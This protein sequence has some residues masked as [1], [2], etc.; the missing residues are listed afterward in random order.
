M[1]NAKNMNNMNPQAVEAMLAIA[2][3]KLGVSAEELKNQLEQGK[4]DNALK[5]VPPKQAQMLKQ[6][7][8]DKEKTE[9]I[10]NSPQAKELMRK[11]QGGK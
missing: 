11:L 10:L 7:L 8:S 4:L 5:S 3:K 2:S 9:K 1:N 6:A